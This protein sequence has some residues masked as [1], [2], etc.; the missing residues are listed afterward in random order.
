MRLLLDTHALLWWWQGNPRLSRAAR[1][2]I[3]A[4]ANVVHVSA[5]TA[6]EL[7][8]KVRIGKLPEAERFIQGF[9]E[10]LAE[11][12]FQSLPITIE[13]G[14]RA[15]LLEGSHKDPFDRILAAQALIE[16][17]AIVTNDEKIARFGARTVW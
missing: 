9:Q 17:C 2:A 3:N 11:Q 14:Q 13:H 15:G 5:A 4:E 8:T 6:W 7:A 16:D 12:G 10:G 1:E